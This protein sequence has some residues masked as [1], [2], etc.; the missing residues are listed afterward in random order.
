MQSKLQNWKSF[1]KNTWKNKALVVMAIP[2]LA[3]MIAF[4]YVPMY[5]AILAFK[6]FNFMQGF[7]SPWCGLDNFKHLF[8]TGDL[9]WRMTR[10][11]IGYYILFTVVGTIA[12]V[13]LAIGLNEMIHK[14]WAKFLQSC[15]VLPHFISYIAIAFIV[16]ALLGDDSGVI[17]QWI[18]R[19]TGNEVN[20]Y[21]EAERWPL[22]LLIVNTWK[23]VGYGSVLYLSV[24]VG[25]DPGLYEAASLD[26]AS[27]WQKTRY[28]TI[29]MLVD[30]VVIQTLLSL[31]GIMKS[32]TGLFYQVTRN[33]GALYPTTQVLSTYVLNA[34]KSGG[35]DYGI[36]G[37]VALYQSLVGTIMVVG[38][39]FV[40]RKIAPEKA[41]F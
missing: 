12:R 26:G 31:G 16:Q 1:W 33:S 40:I 35:A 5:G 29:P 13:M 25:I 37:A 23:E 39:N 28:I 30:M 4:S 7:K 15:I 8:I 41:I 36:T 10:N 24:L 22:I 20:F 27:T 21:V 34:L 11:T 14:R 17:T 18:M 3:L 19:I 38:T 6:D 32:S 9:F 2:A